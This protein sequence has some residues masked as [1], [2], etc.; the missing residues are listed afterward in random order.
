M[1][2]SAALLYFVSRQIAWRVLIRLGL[3]Y[4]DSYIFEII[5]CDMGHREHRNA[6]SLV[7]LLVVI[8]IISVLMGLLLPSLSKARQSAARVKCLSNIRNMETA[9]QIY[10][11]ENRNY[12]VQAGFG[13]GGEVDDDAIAWFNT[14]QSVMQSKLIAR[15][16]ADDSAHWSKDSPVP[17]SG[18]KGFRRTSYGINDFLDIGL[19]P[20]GPGFGAIPAGGAYLKIT[21]IRRPAATVQFL[22]MAQTGNFSGSDHVHVENWVGNNIPNAASKNIQIDAHGGPKISFDSL[23]NYGFLDG[24]AECLRFESVFQSIH[25]NNFDPDIAQ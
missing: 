10:C 15:C 5:G 11:N 8:G 20:W 7:E 17:N 25:K 1:N 14:L 19:C 24:H 2:G 18:G 13:H 9:Q 12:L 3:Q 23:G 22:E 6:F 4:S 21:Q 16:P